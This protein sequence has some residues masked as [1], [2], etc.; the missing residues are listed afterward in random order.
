VLCLSEENTLAYYTPER[1]TTLGSQ[2][3]HKNITENILFAIL[4]KLDRFK[5]ISSNQKQPRQLILFRHYLQNGL[6]LFNLATPLS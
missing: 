3:H 5:T 4:T 6:E 1:F 2:R